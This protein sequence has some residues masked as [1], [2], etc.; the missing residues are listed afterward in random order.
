MATGVASWSK[1]AATNATADSAV[2]WAEGQAPSSVND[3]ARALMASVAK[4]RDDI[5]GT[6]TTGGTSTAYTATSNQVFASFT[7]MNGAL[8]SFIP[9]TTSGVAPTLNVDGLGAKAITGSTGVSI[10]TGELLA[11]TPYL[12]TYLNATT[13]F[14]LVGHAVIATKAEQETGT[15]LN[16]VVTPGHQQ[17]HAS[18]AKAWVK[19][20]G[21]TGAVLA[22]YNCTVTRN[23]VGDYTI[24][25][26]IQMSSAH[27]HGSANC[28]AV[29][30]TGAITVMDRTAAGADSTPSVAGQRFSCYS[31][32]GFGAV[33]PDRVY[34]AAFGDQ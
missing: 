14:I 26:T 6:I 15:A 27:F 25:F 29:A 32:S 20:T 10:N 17:D 33:D 30:G 7:A 28:S 11:G 23:A 18:A 22:S 9:H 31:L 3:S 12:V 13:E 34:Y 8:I 2:N 16:K 19:F 24:L 5:S 21:S 1:T 4:W